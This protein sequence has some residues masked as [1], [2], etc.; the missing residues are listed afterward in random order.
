MHLLAHVKKPFCELKKNARSLLFEVIDLG[1]V[2]LLELIT[3]NYELNNHCQI[4][5]DID[6]VSRLPPLAYTIAHKLRIDV[7]KHLASCYYINHGFT[8]IQ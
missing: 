1:N 7:L 5:A 8:D 2:E 3:K 4:H 6:P